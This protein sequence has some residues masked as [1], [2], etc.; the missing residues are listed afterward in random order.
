M[1]ENVISKSMRR[2]IYQKQKKRETN[3]AMQFRS[4]CIGMAIRCE[5]ECVCVCARAERRAF[6]AEFEKDACG[7]SPLSYRRYPV[8]V[9][10]HEETHAAHTR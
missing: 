9:A 7:L 3:D 10:I 8:L 1:L 2:H 4:I 5:R 6:Y